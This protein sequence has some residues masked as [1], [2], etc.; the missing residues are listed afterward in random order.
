MRSSHFYAGALQA[1][2]SHSSSFT[3]RDVI[4]KPTTL[5][6]K[7]PKTSS[8]ARKKQSN[9]LISDLSNAQ[10]TI[11][12]WM[13]TSCRDWNLTLQLAKNMLYW[14][15]RTKNIDRTVQVEA[16]QI[17]DETFKDVT[18]VAFFSKG[19][20]S[21]DGV[22]VGLVMMEMQGMKGIISHTS[23]QE[24]VAHQEYNNIIRAPCN[25]VLPSTCSRAIQS[26]HNIS[27]N[28]RRNMRRV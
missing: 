3:P 17:I 12:S 20:N 13:N 25:T 10:S 9:K 2:I 27:R 28:M 11:R 5:C 24:S 14:V 18:D 6:E 16:Y 19:E 4:H 21:W 1:T 15:E 23:R 8:I 26:I 7:S 22:K